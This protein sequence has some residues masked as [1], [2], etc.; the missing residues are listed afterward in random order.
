MRTWLRL[1]RGNDRLITLLLLSMTVMVIVLN[2]LIFFVGE[3]TEIWVY[4][5]GV[6]LGILLGTVAV[7]VAWWWGGRRR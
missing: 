6:T 5:G 4:V 2:A 1:E 3:R 7:S